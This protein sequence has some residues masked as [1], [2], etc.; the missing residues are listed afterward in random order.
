MQPFW[1]ESQLTI[2]PISSFR[3]MVHRAFI[4]PHVSHLTI[5]HYLNLSTWIIIITYTTAA[6]KYIYTVA[7]IKSVDHEMC[8]SHMVLNILCANTTLV[9]MCLAGWLERTY[10]QSTVLRDIDVLIQPFKV[11]QSSSLTDI[12]VTSLEVG[13]T[14]AHVP[15]LTQLFCLLS[16]WRYC[17]AL[18]VLQQNGFV[19]LF[20]AS[21]LR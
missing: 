3:C 10:Q 15:L 18:P 13:P 20:V 6:P 19:R 8:H 9:G 1:V 11:S 7:V 2:R 4:Q 16:L 14:R 12:C 5:L 17:R 21:Y